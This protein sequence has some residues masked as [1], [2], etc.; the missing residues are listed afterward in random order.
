MNATT[1]II[2]DSNNPFATAIHL[3]KTN[4]QVW[5]W[6]P[7]GQLVFNDKGRKGYEQYS[8]IACHPDG[9]QTIIESAPRN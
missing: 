4:N 6:A 3:A 1:N 5:Y 9:S 2:R 8:A 7:S